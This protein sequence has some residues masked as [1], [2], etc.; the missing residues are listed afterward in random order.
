MECTETNISLMLSDYFTGHLGEDDHRRVESHL[1][2]CRM[3]RISLRM[4]ALVADKPEPY[5]GSEKQR[6]FSPTLLFRFY[7]DVQ[8]LD[9]TLVKQ[10]EEHLQVCRECYEDLDFLKNSNIDIKNLL[11]QYRKSRKTTWRDRLRRIFK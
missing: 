7:T 4:M 5:A 10:I 1:I 11:G 6:H 9:T 3:C 8:S 2:D